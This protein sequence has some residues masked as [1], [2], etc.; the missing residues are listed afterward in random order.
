[1]LGRD[2]LVEVVVDVFGARCG[3]AELEPPASSARRRLRRREE[4]R[5]FDNDDSKLSQSPVSGTKGVPDV[6]RSTVTA[7]RRGKDVS[8]CI[9]ALSVAHAAKV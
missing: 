7:R 1:M 3:H 5:L 2:E 9:T 6:S 8:R 4:R